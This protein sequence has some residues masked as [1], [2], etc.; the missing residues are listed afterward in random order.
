MANHRRMLPMAK[1]N[2]QNVDQ[3]STR[4]VVITPL[5]FVRDPQMYR[6]KEFQSILSTKTPAN[7][8]L[9]L[10]TKLQ[11]GWWRGTTAKIGAESLRAN[12]TKKKWWLTYHLFLLFF[13]SFYHF[14][15]KINL[16][17][18]YIHQH[19]INGEEEEGKNKTPKEKMQV[20][21]PLISKIKHNQLSDTKKNMNISFNSTIKDITKF[22]Y[23]YTSCHSQ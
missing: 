21:I 7:Y 10:S 15:W 11:W 19:H 2:C 16:D 18:D 4:F 5:G 22:I 23:N 13:K 20:Q 12:P 14:Y 17:H 3:I 9:W 1:Q 6:P 8:C